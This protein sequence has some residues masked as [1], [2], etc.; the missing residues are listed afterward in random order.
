MQKLVARAGNAPASIAS[1][2]SAFTFMLTGYLEIDFQH[3][4]FLRHS[5]HQSRLFI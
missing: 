2:A 1:K 5:T 4:G 3:G